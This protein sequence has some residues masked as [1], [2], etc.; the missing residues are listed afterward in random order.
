MNPLLSKTLKTCFPQL[1]YILFCFSFAIIVANLLVALTINAT[2]ELLKEGGA[3]QSKKKVDDIRTLLK[4]KEHK[5]LTRI[6]NGLCCPFSSI[7]KRF[8]REKFD[9][10]E[11]QT[12]PPSTKN[13]CLIL[14]FCVL[15]SDISYWC[16]AQ[17]N[18]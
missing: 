10:K 15:F 16:Q 9:G 4:L 11:V 12:P 5:W 18:A 3:T 17:E 8:A 14:F 7:C 2:D 6:V 13:G 1:L